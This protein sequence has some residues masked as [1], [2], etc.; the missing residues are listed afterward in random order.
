MRAKQASIACFARFIWSL[1]T[2]LVLMGSQFPAEGA[3]GFR[4]LNKS[5]HRRTLQAAEK[6]NFTESAKNGSRQNAPR[7]IRGPSLMIFYPPNF[8]L[9][10]SIRSFSAACL[11]V[12]CYKAGFPAHS[13]GTSIHLS[14]ID[15]HHCCPAIS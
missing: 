9:S 4:L 5:R 7:A 2:L 6:L 10:P 8:A 13:T 3:G 14:K 12:P 1:F 11:V 15:I